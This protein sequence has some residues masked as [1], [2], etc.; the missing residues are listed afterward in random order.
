[1]NENSTDNGRT[2]I[3]MSA[4]RAWNKNTKQMI[5]TITAC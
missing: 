5:V 4:D 2:N 3:T 1:M